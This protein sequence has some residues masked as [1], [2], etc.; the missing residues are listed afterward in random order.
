[1]TFTFKPAFVAAILMETKQNRHII[2]TDCF[3]AIAMTLRLSS[4]QANGKK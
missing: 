1:M 4:V 2:L 3:S